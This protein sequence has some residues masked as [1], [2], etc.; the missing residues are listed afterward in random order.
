M[1]TPTLDPNITWLGKPFHPC[2]EGVV[3]CKC[4]QPL[5]QGEMEP[6]GLG[7]NAWHHL[8]NNCLMDYEYAAETIPDPS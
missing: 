7:M 2:C 1:T 4:G 5:E 8:C 6:V 3:C